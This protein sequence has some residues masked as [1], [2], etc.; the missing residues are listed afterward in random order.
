MGNP[1]DG[2]QNLVVFVSEN[3]V[4]VFAHDFQNQVFHSHVAHFVGRFHFDDDDT[5]EI[6]LADI[7]DFTAGNVFAQYHAE[8]WCC[9]GVFS[10]VCIRG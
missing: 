10:G 1:F 6:G 8:Q 7:D 9:H 5:L 3:Q 2:I 4:T